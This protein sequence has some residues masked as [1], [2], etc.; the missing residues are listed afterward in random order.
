M[1]NNDVFPGGMMTMLMIM[2]HAHMEMK[3]STP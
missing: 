3:K 2:P 1:V